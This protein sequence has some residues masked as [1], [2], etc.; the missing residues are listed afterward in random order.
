MHPSA[1]TAEV[2]ALLRGPRRSA[3]I[4]YRSRHAVY[5]RDRDHH[6]AVLSRDAVAVPCGLQTTWPDV[7]AVHSV[8]LG[9]GRCSVDGHDLQVRRF[10]EARVSPVADRWPGRP[11]PVGPLVDE[12]GTFLDLPRALGGRTP[13]AA[14]QADDDAAVGALLGRGPGLTPLGDDVLAGWLVAR[15]ALGH[16]GGHVAAAVLRRAPAWTT[17]VSAAL[18]VHAVRGEAVPQLRALVEGV[19]RPD[20]DQRLADLRGV[21]HTS[22]V[23]LALGVALAAPSPAAAAA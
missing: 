1:A 23:G 10:V 19:G 4:V 7:D 13:Y 8:V 6:L 3:E 9:D 18:L 20:A 15:Y 12:V 16:R 14:L 22:G 5:V 2:A 11:L 21:G 17:T